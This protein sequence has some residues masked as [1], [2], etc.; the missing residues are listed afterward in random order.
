MAVLSE[1]PAF[2]QDD[3]AS[4]LDQITFQTFPLIHHFLKPVSETCS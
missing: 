3:P 4:A 2:L 1:V